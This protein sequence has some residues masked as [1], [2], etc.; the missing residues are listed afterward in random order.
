MNGATNAACVQRVPLIM[1]GIVRNVKNVLLR[2]IL[3]AKTVIAVLPVLKSV[4][5]AAAPA[6]NAVLSA[7]IAA[8]V[9]IVQ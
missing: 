4:P 1:T 9:K 8:L 5:T 2:Q 6:A 7:K 3:T